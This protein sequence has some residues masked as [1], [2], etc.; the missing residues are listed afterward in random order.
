MNLVSYM[1]V[2]RFD[3]EEQSTDGYEKVGSHN[4]DLADQED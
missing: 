1:L 2:A 4:G 3:N